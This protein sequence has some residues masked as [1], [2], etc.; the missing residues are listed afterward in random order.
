MVNDE[1]IYTA[2]EGNLITWYMYLKCVV[3]QC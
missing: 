2:L 3:S 1:D